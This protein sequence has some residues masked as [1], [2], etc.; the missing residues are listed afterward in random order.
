MI[1][2]GTPEA[3]AVL[4]AEIAKID[5]VCARIEE[6]RSE[7]AAL[8][9]KVESKPAGSKEREKESE[10]TFRRRLWLNQHITDLEDG[11]ME[12]K[13]ALADAIRTAVPLAI[14]ALAPALDESLSRLSDPYGRYQLV[15]VLVERA[16]RIEA[17][18]A[19]ACA[20][21][22]DFSKFIAHRASETLS[23][24]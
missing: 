24:G 9:Q 2:T 1:P 7:L 18:L 6:A 17:I 13:I 21:S 8:E 5:P 11:S 3:L 23:A 10:T 4:Q 22:P 15:R 16:R 12:K 14:G 19:E 20:P